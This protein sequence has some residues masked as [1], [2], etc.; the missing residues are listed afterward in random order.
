LIELFSI[1]PATRAEPKTITAIQ[2]HLL[3]FAGSADRIMGIAIFLIG[4]AGMNN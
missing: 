4:I 2:G 1:D 3:L